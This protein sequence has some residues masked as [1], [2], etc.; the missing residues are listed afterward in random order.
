[1][2]IIVQER[3]WN[4]CERERFQVEAEMLKTLQHPNIV[5]FYDFFEIELMKSKNTVVL[6]TELMTSGTLK[7]YVL[8]RLLF[9]CKLAKS[10]CED[11]GICFRSLL[12]T[13]TCI[14]VSQLHNYLVYVV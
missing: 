4:K 9:G 7:T 3:T 11:P 13:C 5:R 8:H 12:S 2:L 6:V 14:Y 10:V 1:M